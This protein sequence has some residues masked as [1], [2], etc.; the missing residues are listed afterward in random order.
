MKYR[1][2]KT[3]YE[4]ESDCACKGADLELVEGKEA[5]KKPATKKRTTVKK[6]C[7]NLSQGSQ[8]LR[9]YTDR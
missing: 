6:Q 2:T 5:D 8:T 7:M 3:G 1:N 4:F 9:P